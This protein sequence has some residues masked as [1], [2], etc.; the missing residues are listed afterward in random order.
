[1]EDLLGF[2]IGLAV[3]LVVMDRVDSV[4]TNHGL[5]EEQRETYEKLRKEYLEETQ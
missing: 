2:M 1:M 3:G 4:I 5:L